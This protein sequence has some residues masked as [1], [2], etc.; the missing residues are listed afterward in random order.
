MGWPSA[1]VQTFYG[2]RRH[3]LFGIADTIILH[4]SWGE[5]WAQNCSYGSLKAHRDAISS[6]VILPLVVATIELWEWR[7][8]RV[9]R[10]KPWFVRRQARGKKAWGPLSE[11]EGPLE[12]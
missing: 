11:W 5:V 1:T 4:P 12:L 8:K 7:K 9:G 10:K 6:N 3:D 2:G